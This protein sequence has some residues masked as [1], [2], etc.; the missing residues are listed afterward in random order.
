VKQPSASTVDETTDPLLVAMGFDPI[1]IDLLA[2]RSN[3][4]AEEISA[5]LLTLELDGKVASL[6]GG[7]YQRIS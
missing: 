2:I 3:L 4:S 6:P 7:L 5:Q 1:G